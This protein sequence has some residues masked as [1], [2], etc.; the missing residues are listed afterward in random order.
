M[1]KHF[2]LSAGAKAHLE[3]T[4]AYYDRIKPL[5]LLSKAYRKMLAH[6]YNLLIPSGASVLEVGCGEGD[7]LSM[8]NCGSKRGVDVSPQQIS[9]AKER[10]PEIEFLVGAGEQLRLHDSKYDVII[11]RAV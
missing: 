7:L 10:F 5:G 9:K 3:F 4:R 6:R 2:N 1:T 11:L 8:L